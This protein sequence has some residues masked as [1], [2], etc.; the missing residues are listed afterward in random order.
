M[1]IEQVLVTSRLIL[2]EL[3]E[4]N[5]EDFFVLIKNEDINRFSDFNSLGKVSDEMLLLGIILKSGELFIGSCGLKLSSKDNDYNC[6]YALLPQYWG[7]G[8]AVES[9][10]RLF[11]FAFNDLGADNISIYLHP[12]NSRAWKVAE[13]SGMMYLGQFKLKGE[14]YDQMYYHIEK[15]DYKTQQYY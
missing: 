6:F 13:R 12:E 7:N 14:V 5:L 3:S 10:K 1:K 8:Y 11:D 15:K 2:R 4:S 9:L